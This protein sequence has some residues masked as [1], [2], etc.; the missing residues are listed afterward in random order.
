MPVLKNPRHERFAQ[1]LASGKTATDAYEEAGYKRN[2]GNSSV[3]ANRP[4]ITARVKEIK[5]IAAD[6]AAVTRQSL[7]EK[8]EAVYEQARE[9]GQLGAAVAAA[10]EIGV[11]TGF[12]V[13]RSE[14]GAPGEFD[15]LDKVSAEDLRLAAA[16]KLDLVALRERYR[17]DDAPLR[18][19]P[20]N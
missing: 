4:E 20:L 9:I 2:D 14:R 12:R 17:Q 6:R 18:A 11:L 1:F 5:G 19:R 13:E 3:A 15:W 16:G 7:I 8:V 10:K